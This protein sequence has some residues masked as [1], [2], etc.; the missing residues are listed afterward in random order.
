VRIPHSLRR[1]GDLGDE[2]EQSRRS[3]ATTLTLLALSLAIAC[4]TQVGGNVELEKRSTVYTLFWPQGWNF[5]TDLGTNTVLSAYRTDPVGDRFVL[6][7]QR[8]D[9]SD[10][11]WGLNRSGE[12]AAWEITKLAGQIP[13]AAWRRCD[14]AT[15]DG[16]KSLLAGSAP[17]PLTN[18]AS[19]PTLC[20]RTVFA[21]ERSN[22]PVGATLPSSPRRIAVVTEVDVTCPR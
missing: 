4:V 22:Y 15:V 3:F 21:V 9:W 18:R 7:T 5:F 19:A 17:P 2:G 6:E 13:Q 14:A 20:G 16:C 8:Q 1:R 12:A 11:R 10:R